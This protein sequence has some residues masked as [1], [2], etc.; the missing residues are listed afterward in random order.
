[1]LI[2]TDPMP[3]PA[4][5]ELISVAARHMLIITWAIKRK[6][7]PV[8]MPESPFSASLRVYICSCVGRSLV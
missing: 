6:M 3:P 2:P 8:A 7:V 4:S 1:M 5:S